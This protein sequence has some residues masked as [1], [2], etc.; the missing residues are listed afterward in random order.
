MRNLIDVI[1]TV[2]AFKLLEKTFIKGLTN[3]KNCRE[4]KK[5]A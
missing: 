5:S 4:H 3:P 2:Y 1:F